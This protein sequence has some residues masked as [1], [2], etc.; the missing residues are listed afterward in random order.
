MVLMLMIG[1]L[2]AGFIP[3]LK[4]SASMAS[5]AHTYRTDT[6]SIRLWLAFSFLSIILL[7][8]FGMAIAAQTRRIEGSTPVL[9]YIQVASLG[10][11]SMIFVLPWICWFVAAFRPGR[12]ASEIM[13]MND[14]GWITF[15]TAFVAFFAWLFAVGVAILSDSSRTP[16]FPRWVGYLNLFVAMSFIPDICVPFFKTGAFSWTGVLPFWF[17]F[18]TYLVWIIVMMVYTSN[19]IKADP[20][21]TVA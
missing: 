4:P 1:L 11:G 8:P 13:L 10:S 14:F 5:I 7:F 9:T 15:V 16:I 17:P 3:P 19:A 20:E 12:S 6:N 21:L 18:S 2:A